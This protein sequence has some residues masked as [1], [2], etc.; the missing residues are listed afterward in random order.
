M[1]SNQCKICQHYQR[2]NES[3]KLH[4]TAFPDGIPVEIITG[5]HNHE[6]EY[7]GDNGIRWKK[8]VIKKDD[9]NQS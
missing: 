3:G 7:G 2:E 8:R 9:R 5:E 1:Q 4:C 6:K